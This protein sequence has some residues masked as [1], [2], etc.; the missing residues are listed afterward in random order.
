MPKQLTDQ[1]EIF[2]QEYAGSLRPA[3]AAEAAN[4]S[5]NMGYKLLSQ[6]MI[7]ARID[8]IQSAR[9]KQML[10]NQT[11]V[12]RQAAYIAGS[13]ITEVLSAANVRDLQLM[14]ER[15]RKAIRRVKRKRQIVGETVTEYLEVEMHAKQPALELLAR[16]TGA[17]KPDGPSDDTPALVGLVVET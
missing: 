3:E 12:L 6:P 13:D 8:E 7:R 9:A 5:R 1:H 16:A 2:C 11:E 10:I 17:D 4:F 15:V 14:P